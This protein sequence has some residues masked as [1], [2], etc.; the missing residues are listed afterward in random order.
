[1]IMAKPAHTMP[2]MRAEK[3]RGA[4]AGRGQSED[5]RL[6]A[7]GKGQS[8]SWPVRGLTF[9][10]TGVEQNA[11][12]EPH[13]GRQGQ[14]VL[15]LLFTVHLEPAKGAAGTEGGRERAAGT[16]LPRPL[17]PLRP[18]RSW[19][20]GPPGRAH[21]KRSSRY[22]ITA[23]T[24]TDSPTSSHSVL[25]KGCMNES[26]VLRGISCGWTGCQRPRPAHLGPPLA[27]RRPAPG[28]CPPSSPEW[29]GPG[30]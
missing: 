11:P 14:R 27:P 16:A 18:P 2:R 21:L 6:L 19:R 20:C 15:L 8:R 26:S 25:W 3:L 4:P 23:T 12:G 10:D 29:S 7:G 1:M 9:P 28:P 17:A 13:G 30:T 5:S 24:C 22:S